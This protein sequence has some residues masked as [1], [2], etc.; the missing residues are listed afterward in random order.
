MKIRNLF[1]AL[2]AAAVILVS[3]IPVSAENFSADKSKLNTNDDEPALS[4]DSNEWSGYVKT[5][6][7]ADRIGLKLSTENT[8]TYQGL[9]LKLTGGSSTVITHD[10]TYSKYMKDE[11]GKKLY[12]KAGITGMKPWTMGI[13]IS[14]KSFGMKYFDGCLVT[15]NYRFSE[16]VKDK[17]MSDSLFVYPTDDYYKVIT[18]K[19][20]Q[21]TY[22]DPQVDNVS[23]YGEGMLS[24]APGM[25]ATKIVFEVPLLKI[26][27][28]S[29]MIYLD[30]IKIDTP[31][32]KDGK[33]LS[34]ANVDGY[35][36]GAEPQKI[37]EKV[38]VKEQKD[39]GL[40][41]PVKTENSSEKT[42]PWLVVGIVILGIVVVAGIVIVIIKVKNKY[43]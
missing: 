31:L 1:G 38:Q 15:F 8:K 22:N 4:F 10:L 9:S 11:N 29:D 2:A 14:A 33:T 36:K 40:K 42:N 35:N 26:M 23:Q 28:K 13:E 18:G 12:P 5:T 32:S 16:N 24:V 19:P 41:E 43:Y 27:K 39:A 34:V 30:N 20:L 37:N 17:L 7:D 3:S 6:Q 21:L 25:K